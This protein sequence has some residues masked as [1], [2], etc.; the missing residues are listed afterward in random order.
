MAANLDLQKH[1]QN[2]AKTKS[3]Y[4]AYRKSGY[5]QKYYEAHRAEITLYQ[6][7][8][9]AFRSTGSKMLPTIRELRQ[10]YAALI[11]KKKEAYKGYR[12]AKQDMKDYL[13][14]R[15]NVERF[16]G[17]DLKKEREEAKHQR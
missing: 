1:I 3:V 13:M 10:E 5:S 14:T 7:A 8:K 15:Q 11:A 4:Q 12:K 6:A 17:E 9:E 2:Y 16:Y